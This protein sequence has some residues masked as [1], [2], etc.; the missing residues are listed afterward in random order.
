MSKGRPD[1]AR[2]EAERALELRRRVGEVERAILDRAP[3]HDPEP[4]LDRVALAMQLL[5]DPQHSFPVVHLTGTNGKTTTTRVIERVLRETG[6]STG[7]FTSPHLHTMRERISLNGKAIE[8]ER[9]VAI[10]DEVLPYIEMVDARS[11]EQGGPR[12]TYFEV[13]VVLAYAAFADAPVDVAV[14]EVGLGGSW[15]ATNVAD[16]AVAVL[17]PI[18][19]DHT[20]LLGSTV[21]EITMEKRGISSLS[22]AAA[23]LAGRLDVGDVGDRFEQHVEALRDQSVDQR[24]HE[25]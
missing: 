1:A 23:G 10:Y 2:I 15:D 3:E 5:G 9:F 13:L 22:I 6:L 11:T 7:R 16:G 12:M 21:E 17:T 20:R 24:T 19:L 14:V 8:P 25:E 18:S 4:S